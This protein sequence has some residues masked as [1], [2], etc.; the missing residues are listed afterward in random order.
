MNDDAIG[1]DS[2]SDEKLWSWIDREALELN[3]YLERFPD[4][5]DRV[6]SI[7]RS[8]R[9]IADGAALPGVPIPTRIGNYVVTGIL[10]EGG[11]G[12]VYAAEQQNPKRA[13][14]IKVIRH[15]L[16][17][18]PAL[19][20]RF[21]REAR[22]LAKLT[23]P[24]IAR[25]HE[26]GESETGQH[27]LVMELVRGRTLGAYRREEKLSIDQTLELFLEV[28]AAVDAAHREGVVH[29]DLKPGNILVGDDGRLR[30]L[31]FGLARLRE[32]EMLISS[33]GPKASP[34]TVTV[35]PESASVVGT[36]QYMSP[37]QIRGE[38]ERLDERTD[39]YALGVVLYEL[40]TG[41]LPYDLSSKALPEIARIICERPPRR[42]EALNSEIRGDLATIVLKAME[43]DS[44]RRY[45]T[46]ADLAADIERFRQGRPVEA[47]PPSWAYRATKFVGRH[48][49]S[50]ALVA[51][52]VLLVGSL[53]VVD[54]GSG[55]DFLNPLVGGRGS[56]ERSPFERVRWRGDIPI[57]EVGGRW[58]E[59][60]TID[61]IRV[62]LLIEL[63]RQTEDSGRWRKRF[64]EDL[65]QVFERM[66]FELGRLV[67]V[68]A[69]DLE[70]EDVIEL[71]DVEATR[72]KR[73]AVLIDRNRLP[74]ED[75]RIN[76]EA[77]RLEVFLRGR[78]WEL[79]SVDGVAAADIMEQ[80]RSRDDPL[81][82]PEF[83]PMAGFGDV[84]I[85][86]RGSSLG[87]T[88]D[89]DLR[90]L[91]TARI[92]TFSGLSVTAEKGKQAAHAALERRRRAEEER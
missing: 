54:Y 84:L 3:A 67:S 23:H 70:T 30:I 10:G 36:P 5:S 50:S 66:G 61:G 47:R 17:A 42:P 62:P 83:F 88:V 18:N 35:A 46:A 6:E 27:F 20:A 91:S 82:L 58:Y 15:Q 2:V 32:G 38:H 69:R 37:E 11:M 79:V 90:D 53:A 4:E 34:E 65:C 92:E 73:R 87:D 16:A 26:A 25:V 9:G 1:S 56:R 64:S 29:R 39:V 7:R 40:L 80:S 8:I 12:I 21:R 49:V 75:M 60:L 71:A 59:P 48:K 31:D 63:C 44:G 33:T 77:D 89:V 55:L 74:F 13:V 68:R 86:L 52:L 72:A 85:D 76:R 78:W 57:V 24:G 41:E 45:R 19:V 28:T 22:I 51:L 43:K 81:V 14:A